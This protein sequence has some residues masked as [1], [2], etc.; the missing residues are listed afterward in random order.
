V[1]D[2]TQKIILASGVKDIMPDIP[3]LLSAGGFLYCIARIAT[4]MK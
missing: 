3:V 1:K 4:D 2:F